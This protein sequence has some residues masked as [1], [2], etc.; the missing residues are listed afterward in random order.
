MQTKTTAK[1]ARRPKHEIGDKEAVAQEVQDAF[2]NL[3][4]VSTRALWQSN[5]IYWIRS[6]KTLLNYVSIDRRDE[7]QPHEVGENSGTRYLIPVENI[8]RFI[9]NYESN[10]L[11]QKTDS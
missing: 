3:P 6:Y 8:T 10:L 11:G 4:Y 5:V 7:F 9:N 2:G 1:N